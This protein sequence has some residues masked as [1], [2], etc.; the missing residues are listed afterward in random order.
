MTFSEKLAAAVEK[1]NS[2]LC[3]GLDPDVARLPEGEDQLRF[4][5]AIIDATAGLVCAFKPNAAFFESQGAEGIQTLKDICDYLNQEYAEIPIILDYKR[6]DIDNTN[7]Q[8]A[9]FAYDYLGVDAVTYQPYMGRET[10]APLLKYDNKAIFVLVRTSNPGAGEVQDLL[11]DGMPLYE[12]IAKQITEEWNDS[13]NVMMVVGAT[14]PEELSRI[15]NITGPAMTFLVPGVGAQGANPKDVIQAGLGNNN[16][17]LIINASRSII[18]AGNSAANFAEAARIKAT[19][20]R[21]E[22]NKYRGDDE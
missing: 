20:L 13:G 5:K 15:R 1:H 14:Y 9:Q 18:F 3:V 6:G 17:G 22:I 8:Y 19:E 12:H 21:D 11:V 2:L 4:S 16:A 10:I 7:A